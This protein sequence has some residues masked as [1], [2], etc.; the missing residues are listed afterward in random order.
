[1]VV[2]HEDRGAEMNKT[3]A[4]KSID[5]AVAVMMKVQRDRIIATAADELGISRQEAD[6]VARMIG[7]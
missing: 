6:R 7:R 3:A 2:H 1:M 5:N 4:E